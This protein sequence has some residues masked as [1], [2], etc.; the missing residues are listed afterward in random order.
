MEIS[1]LKV[2]VPF[3]YPTSLIKYRNKEFFYH[4]TC[5]P[6]IKRKDKSSVQGVF[7]C[8]YIGGFVAECTSA[9]GQY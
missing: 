8:L 7:P 9:F 3:Y 4:Q 6:T 1:V 2:I 5:R